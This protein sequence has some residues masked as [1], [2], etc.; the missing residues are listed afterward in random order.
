MKLRWPNAKKT[1]KK[2]AKFF[3]YAV[4]ILVALTTILSFMPGLL[5]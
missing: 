2:I 1:A 4:I 3:W 5:Y